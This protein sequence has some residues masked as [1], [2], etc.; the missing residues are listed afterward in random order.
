MNREEYIS[1]MEKSL[2]G[3]IDPDV[4][5][6]TMAY[7]NDYFAMEQSKGLSQEQIIS[8]LGDP[9]LLAKSII[10][11][12]SEKRESAEHEVRMGEEDGEY[13][14]RVHRSHIP[15]GILILI[16]VLV[17]LGVIGLIFSIASVLLPILLPALVVFGIITFFKNR[18]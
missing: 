15:F 9:R 13:G 17:F 4:L 10:A 18:F 12:E 3:R 14:F 7:Y 6:D 16:I 8:N 1:T 11:A 5:R 2:V